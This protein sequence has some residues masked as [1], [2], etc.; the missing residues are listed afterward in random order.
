MGQELTPRGVRAIA[1][2]IAGTVVVVTV[3]VLDIVGLVD[4]GGIGG[5]LFL[6][7]AA[8][9]LVIIWAYFTIDHLI[10]RRKERQLQ[11]AK[12]LLYARLLEMIDEFLSVVLPEECR[13]VSTKRYKYRYGDIHAI[14][15]IELVGQE[16]ASRLPSLIARDI[17]SRGTFYREPLL[18]L[19]KQLDATLDHSLT[20]LEPEPMKLV[21]RL[22][23]VFLSSIPTDTIETGET[24]LYT[25]REEPET[26]QVNR[27]LATVRR[28]FGRETAERTPEQRKMAISPQDFFEPT[29]DGPQ[30]G[31]V[32]WLAGV[33]S[34]TIKV[35]TWLERMLDQFFS[36]LT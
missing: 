12:C 23:F 36:P 30:T 32:L 21:L 19:R 29:E 15:S 18:Q 7:L 10:K 16:I 34:A 1:L 8:E 31:L 20:L 4:F 9:T 6:N 5:D 11:P 27:I 33:I 2:V 25:L 35:R 14:P 13:K 24:P 28:L 3:I 22:T 26:G 17:E